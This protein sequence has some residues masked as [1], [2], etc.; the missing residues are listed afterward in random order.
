MI[1]PLTPQVR[2]LDDGRAEVRLQSVL[3][4]HVALEIAALAALYGGREP[5]F[6]PANDDGRS[7]SGP[8]LTAR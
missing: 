8:R 7:S 6:R 5:Q 2:A 4:L 1:Q 3:P